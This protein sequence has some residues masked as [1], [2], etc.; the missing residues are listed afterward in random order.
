MLTVDL[1]TGTTVEGLRNISGGG[2]VYVE[3]VLAKQDPRKAY[4]SAPIPL[5]SDED[6]PQFPER[7]EL[8]V[9][10]LFRE[11]KREFG[12]LVLCTQCGAQ[13]CK[14]A[15]GQSMAV[16]G[17]WPAG[18]IFGAGQTCPSW[19]EKRYLMA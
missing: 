6:C 18:R 12:S 7:F 13:S 14:C 16:S 3:V 19:P 11:P 15:E 17:G 1:R 4:T 2:K 10:F 8:Y 9:P 5:A